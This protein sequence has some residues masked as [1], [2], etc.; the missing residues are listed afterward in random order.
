MDIQ[1]TETD[2]E[3]GGRQFYKAEHFAGK[4]TFRVRTHQRGESR[5][6]QPTRAM[7][8]IILENLER[9]YRRRE[10]VD[11]EDIER[12]KKILRELPEPPALPEK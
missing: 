1:W 6:M 10:G 5:P 3:T 8:E 9:R 12:V 4:W 11:D 2:P 7:W